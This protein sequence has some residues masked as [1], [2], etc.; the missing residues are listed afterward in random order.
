VAVLLKFFRSLL[1]PA[2]IATAH[3]ISRKLHWGKYV[4]K[5]TDGLLAYPQDVLTNG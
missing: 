3:L 2:A 1:K 5:S 4:Q